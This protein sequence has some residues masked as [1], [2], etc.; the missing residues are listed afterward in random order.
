MAR[1]LTLCLSVAMV[2]AQAQDGTRPETV[3]EAKKLAAQ[4]FGQYKALLGERFRAKVRCEV[5]KSLLERKILQNSPIP[6]ALDYIYLYNDAGDTSI[7]IRLPSIPQPLRQQ[8]E[9]EANRQVKST[10]INRFVKQATYDLVHS[11]LE[12]LADSATLRIVKEDPAYLD[13]EVTGVAK[14]VSGSKTVD[15]IR[16]RLDREKGI[17]SL[18]KFTFDDATYVMMKLFYAPLKI[19]KKDVTLQAQSKV[20]I[21]HD[22]D[23]SGGPIQLPNKFGV[24]FSGYEF[25]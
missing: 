11:G 14:S 13:A 10:E 25:R 6:I 22:L 21:R 8:A 16:M 15:T 17:V 2:S 4:A 5:L 7:Q 24:E 12:T 19:P 3:A 1:I 23:L 20:L 9:A 18:A